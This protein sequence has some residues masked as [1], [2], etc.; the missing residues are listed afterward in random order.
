[1]K[2]KWNP[3]TRGELN[4]NM[5]NK[6]RSMCRGRPHVDGHDPEACG[7]R[8]ITS[9]EDCENVARAQGYK[10]EGEREAKSRQNGCILMLVKHDLNNKKGTPNKNLPKHKYVWWNKNPDLE[11]NKANEGWRPLQTLCKPLPTDPEC[12]MIA[13]QECAHCDGDREW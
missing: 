6:H 8:A 1:M 4:P 5:I 11:G 2:V 10:W 12:E 13:K 7:A 9:A 3:E